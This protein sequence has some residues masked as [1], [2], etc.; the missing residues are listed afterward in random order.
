MAMTQ[1]QKQAESHQ[2]AQWAFRKWKVEGNRFYRYKNH[3]YLRTGSGSGWLIDFAK[4][5]DII[6]EIWNSGGLKH[7]S[8]INKKL[9]VDEILSLAQ[10][11]SLPINTKGCRLEDYADPLYSELEKVEAFVNAC[12]ARNT[13]KMKGS[14][15]ED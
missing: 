8:F 15:C 9:L 7:P 13:Y 12:D 5:D 11:V 3:F 2:I 10:A 14:K 1:V 6:E 4:R